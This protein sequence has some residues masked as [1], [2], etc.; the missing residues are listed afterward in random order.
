MF[1]CRPKWLQ[2]LARGVVV[3]ALMVGIRSIGKI[4]NSV[5]CTDIA[6]IFRFTNKVSDYYLSSTL[7]TTEKYFGFKTKE[8][9][10]VP[11]NFI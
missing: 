9:S 5:G 7:S 8:M 1:G 10:L 4:K 11:I 2:S 3:V 6:F